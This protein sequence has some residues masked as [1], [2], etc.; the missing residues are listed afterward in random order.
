MKHKFKYC[1]SLAV[2]LVIATT[3]CSKN[4]ISESKKIGTSN[5]I[6]VVVSFNPMKEFVESIGK[7]KVNVEMVVTPGLEPHDFEPKVKDIKNISDAKIFV[8]NGLG[9]EPWA[10]KTLKSTSNEN[11]IIVEASKGID[12]IK[13]DDKADGKENGDNDPH[14]WLSLKGAEKSAENIKDA[15]IKVDPSSKDFYE[16]NYKEFY[17]SLEKLYNEYKNK[18]ST[19][20]NKN[21][22]TGHAAFAYLCREYNLNQKSVEGVFAEGEPSAKNIKELIDYSKKNNI[23]TIF[24]EELVSPKVA[25][26][27]AREIGG[28]NEKI[29]TLENKEDNKNYLESMKSN[30][31]KIYLS[32]PNS[33]LIY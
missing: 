30:L 13:S 4:Q 5:K 11:L 32:Y 7:D 27:L 12:L 29:Y 31:E 3:G 17:D 25:E 9:M 22:V 23:K 16:E 24:T 8:Y 19:I 20:K 33:K 14:T 21:F 26:T 1:I 28:T 18:F 10:I 6:G 2:L 15:L